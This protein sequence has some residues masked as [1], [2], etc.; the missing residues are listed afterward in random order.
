MLAALR[1]IPSAE[2]SRRGG[3]PGSCLAVEEDS[4]IVLR[5]RPVILPALVGPW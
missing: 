5:L 1:P 2:R 3:K 4:S